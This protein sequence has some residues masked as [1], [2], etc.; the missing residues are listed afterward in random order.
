MLW[1][2]I[3]T[4]FKEEDELDLKD[5]RILRGDGVGLT[6]SPSIYEVVS[7]QHSF[8]L[9]LQESQRKSN[10]SSIYREEK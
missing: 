8:F 6:G 4:G 9:I 7:P 2:R 3:K 5:V 10:T 1:S